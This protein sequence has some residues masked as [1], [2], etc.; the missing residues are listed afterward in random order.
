MADSIIGFT[1][2]C[3]DVL[4]VGHI[5][6]LEYLKTECNTVI[7]A[8]DSDKRVK[9]LKGDSRPFNRQE[10]R[11]YML[12]SLRFVD[13]VLIFDS[14]KELEDII[15]LENPDLMVIGSDYRNKH[16][17]GAQHAKKIEFFEKIN[18]YSTTK[19]LESRLNR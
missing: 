5:K 7:I 9:E 19:I 3:Y 2:G 11:K 17:V 14:E 13:K 1:N 16:V 10:D 8:I 6:L 4:H 15:A 12:K 18:G